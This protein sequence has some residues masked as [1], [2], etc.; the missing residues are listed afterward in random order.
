MEEVSISEIESFQLLIK[1]EAVDRQNDSEPNA[2]PTSRR[3]HR[4][5]IGT[6]QNEAIDR[7]QDRH[8]GRKSDE[9][10]MEAFERHIVN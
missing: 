10:E 5:A 9:E 4:P 3:H 2:A 8:E 6:D 7:G 1:A